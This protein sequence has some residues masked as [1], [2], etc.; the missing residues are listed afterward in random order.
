MKWSEAQF[1][2]RIVVPVALLLAGGVALAM[3][4]SEPVEEESAEFFVE[5]DQAASTLEVEEGETVVIAAAVTNSGELDGTQQVG[6]KVDELTDAATQEISLDAG[7]ETVVDFEIATDAGDAGTYTAEVWTEDDGDTVEV[8]VEESQ[9]EE[10]TVAIDDAASSLDV[11]E[12]DTV[13]VAVDVENVGHAEGAQFIEFSI[14]GVV[15]HTAGEIV[16]DP[17]ESV[18]VNFEWDTEE[19]DGG[20]YTADV[21]SDDDQ[22]SADITVS[23][24]EVLATLEGAV[25]DADTGEPLEPVEVQLFEDGDDEAVDSVATGTD[26]EFQFAELEPGDYELVLQAPG[27][28]PGHT[29]DE[30][31]EGNVVAVTVDEDTVVQ[32]LTVDWLRQT[33]LIVDG[34]FIELDYEPTDGMSLDLPGCEDGEDGWEPIPSDP[35]DDIEVSYDPEDVCFQL[36]DVDVSVSGV[37]D[38]EPADVVFPDIT[39]DVDDENGDIH[40]ALESA[41]VTLET[42]VDNASGMVDY[43]EGSL[44]VGLDVRFLISGEAHSAGFTGYFGAHEET[45]AYDCQLTGGWGGGDLEDPEVDEDDLQLGDYVHDPIEMRLTTGESGPDGAEGA[46]FDSGV[47][48]V[49]DNALEVGR[50][51]EG[52]HGGDDAGGASC[53]EF[54][55][56]EDEEIDFAQMI[57]DMLNLP[58]EEGDVL[59]EFDFLVP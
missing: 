51:S 19:G 24:Q 21:R 30:A 46:G 26:G 16:L 54:T 53:G 2:V 12:G 34:G 37:L 43:T 47:F 56:V 17:G 45:E 40:E 1:Q 41:T 44:D 9:F 14:D 59:I 15:E 23:A 25:E 5:I 29:V 39:A 48:F 10:Y 35:D 8:T 57:N 31:D 36:S 7:A 33:D 20:S 52:E 22:D 11:E 32:D 28:N 6:M 13:E 4:C 38:L 3:A 55:A 42:L 50:L 27:L 49:I 58:N 18:T